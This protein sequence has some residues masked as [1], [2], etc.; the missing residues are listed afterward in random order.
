M[1]SSERSLPT[2][3]KSSVSTE[4]QQC[5]PLLLPKL[6]MRSLP[7]PA[8]SAGSNDIGSAAALTST[9]WWWFSMYHSTGNYHGHRADS[10]TPPGRLGCQFKCRTAAK[11]T[12]LLPYGQPG[13]Q[14]RAALHTGRTSGQGWSEHRLILRAR[15]E[16]WGL[17][18]CNNL[19]SL[20]FW[21]K[22]SKPSD[23][24]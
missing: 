18:T 3:P 13:T 8:H 6:T 1:L 9:Y 17:Q 14:G 24:F 16:A 10:K 12:G 19:L 22:Q 4:E 2:V 11:V 23:Y 7:V 15:W 5:K 21:G 20:C